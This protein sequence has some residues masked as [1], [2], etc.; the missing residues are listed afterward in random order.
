VGVAAANLER[1]GFEVEPAAL[2]GA[3][4]SVDAEAEALASLASSLQHYLEQLGA[5]WGDDEVGQ[6]FAERYVPAASTT[7]AN[8]QALSV[9]LM[10]IAAALRAVGDAYE[11]ADTFEPA[12]T[13]SDLGFG[14]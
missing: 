8:Y 9:G 10:R 3:A 14:P 6:R 2:R 7:L 11:Q 5:C 4:G 13:V 1:Q 12:A